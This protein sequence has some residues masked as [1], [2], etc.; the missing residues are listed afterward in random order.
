VKITIPDAR[1]VDWQRWAA[2]LS[3]QD[4]R[5]PFPPP[6]EEWRRWAREVVSFSS[7]SGIAP[8]ETLGFSNWRDWGIRLKA[9]AETAP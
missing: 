8:P 5:I 4:P 3:F 7:L 2:E 6:E 1:F 9:V